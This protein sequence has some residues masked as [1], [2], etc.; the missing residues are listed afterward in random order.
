MECPAIR[1]APIKIIVAQLIPFVNGWLATEPPFS[2]PY[3]KILLRKMANF[4]KCIDT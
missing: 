3:F 2:L 1:Y 4:L